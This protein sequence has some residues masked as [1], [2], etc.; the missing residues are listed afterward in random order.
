MKKIPQDVPPSA[1]D[2][3]R[4]TTAEDSSESLMPD[5]PIHW[6]RLKEHHQAAGQA[7]LHSVV[8][9]IE[10]VQLKLAI[11][12]R[13]FAKQAKQ[14]LENITPRTLSR[15]RQIGEWYLTAAHGSVAT[16]AALREQD[17]A[18]LAELCSDEEVADYLS[19][20]TL[21]N[22]NELRRHA[23]TK[24]PALL[25]PASAPRTSRVDN[26]ME[27]VRRAWSRMTSVQREE[28]LGCIEELRTKALKV[29]PS[30]ATEVATEPKEEV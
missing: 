13:D 12:Q 11:R 20:S 6:A 24:V 3:Q 17:A 8:A 10:M 27:K 18:P 22:A 14:H 5:L 15:Y 1:P 4:K 9:G 19:A 7:F 30:E 2:G 25:I 23:I 28:F 16:V 21:S 29:I 26:I